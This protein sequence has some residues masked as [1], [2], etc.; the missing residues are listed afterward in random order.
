MRQYAVQ[1]Y[2]ELCDCVVGPYI[3]AGRVRGLL[4]FVEGTIALHDLC[5]DT[6]SRCRTGLVS[7]CQCRAS[8]RFL[9][10]FADSLAIHRRPPRFLR[11]PCCSSSMKDSENC[12]IRLATMREINF[13]P[14]ERRVTPLQLFLLLLG[15]FCFHRGITVACIHE[16]AQC[17]VAVSGRA[18]Q[19]V[20]QRCWVNV[21][22]CLGLVGV[23]I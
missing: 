19:V 8:C 4:A 20:S 16:A 15:C 5:G 17:A 9:R 21:K 12:C 7:H 10:Q 23:P 6:L 14:I 3:P 1:L 22:C 13:T 2:M 18:L 11:K